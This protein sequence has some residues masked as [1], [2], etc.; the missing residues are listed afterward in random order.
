MTPLRR[1]YW[2]L[3]L[4]ALLPPLLQFWPVPDALAP[5]RP[6]FPLVFVGFWASIC[7]WWM[8]GIFAFIYGIVT[9]QMAGLPSGSYAFCCVLLAVGIKGSYSRFQLYSLPQQT[10]FVWAITL[11][12]LWLSVPLRYPIDLFTDVLLLS[13]AVSLTT[14]ACWMLSMSVFQRPTRRFIQ[15]HV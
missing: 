8:G 13:F 11:V 2:L 6:I 4:T 5:W 10:A 3:L 12:G 15:K 14:A 1:N 7:P 9:E